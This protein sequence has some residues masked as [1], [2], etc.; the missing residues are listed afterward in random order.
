MRLVEDNFIEFSHIEFIQ[1]ISDKIDAH[2]NQITIDKAGK[3]LDKCI[4]DSIL[5]KFPGVQVTPQIIKKLKDEN[6]SSKTKSTEN[7]DIMEKK[8]SSIEEKDKEIME[9]KVLSA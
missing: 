9:L 3:H 4:T 7:D 2:L 6:E 5:K 1:R 8:D